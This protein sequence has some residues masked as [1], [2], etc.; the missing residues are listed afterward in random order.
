[1]PLQ[2]PHSCGVDMINT[3]EKVRSRG[4]SGLNTQEK[5]L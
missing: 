4:P 5:R 3:P 1:M 2:E